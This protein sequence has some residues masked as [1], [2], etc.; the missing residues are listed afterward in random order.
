MKEKIKLIRYEI[1]P[2]EMSYGMSYKTEAWDEYGAYTCVYEPTDW[3]AMR[4]ILK[5][6]EGSKERKKSNDLLNRAIHECHQIDR[7]SGILTG[8]RDGLD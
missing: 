1:T 3:E 8:N 2:K 4:Y 6:W 7:K 5:W